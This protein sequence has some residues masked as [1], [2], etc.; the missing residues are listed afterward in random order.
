[1]D[2]LPFLRKVSYAA[3]Q[4]DVDAATP[5]MVNKGFPTLAPTKSLLCARLR[6]NYIE[7]DY[8]Q[9]TPNLKNDVHFLLFEAPKTV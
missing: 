1:M 9:E 3:T 8:S 7:C 2:S 5:R 4:N 6:P